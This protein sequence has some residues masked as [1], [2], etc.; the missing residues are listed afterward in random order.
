MNGSEN[1]VSEAETTIVLDQFSCL[2]AFLMPLEAVFVR[3]FAFL[4]VFTPIYAIL[5]VFRQFKVKIF[6]IWVGVKI[7][8]AN[9]G[10]QIR[11]SR[12]N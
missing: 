2:N 7:D 9:L 8:C 11:E 10:V 5:G 3:F 4:G 12:E 6:Q 1:S